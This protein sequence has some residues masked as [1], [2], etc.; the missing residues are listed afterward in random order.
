MSDDPTLLFTV[1]GMVPFKAYFED[2]AI[3]PRTSVATAQK[4]LR[5]IDI[6]DIGDTSHCTFFEMMGNFSFGDY[7]KREAVTWAWEFLT[8]VLKLNPKDLRVTVFEDDDEAYNLWR[9][10]CGLPAERVTRLGEKTNYWPANAI[11][12]HSQGP[13][14]PCS[15]IFFDRQPD[16]PF[17]NEW[18][19]QG[20]RWLEIWNLV[21]TQFTGDGEGDNYRLVPLPKKNIDT[22][23]GLER[24]AAAINRLSGPF[25][26]DLLRPI[27]GELEALSGKTYTGTPDSALDIAF[28]R[29]A[30]HVRA[31]TFLLSDGVTPDRTGRGYVLRRLMRRAIVAG[32]RA[33]GFTDEPFLA[34][35]VPTVIAHMGDAYPDIREREQYILTQVQ[36]EETLFRRTLQNGLARLDDELATGALSGRRAYFLYETFGLPFE[37]TREIAGERGVSV[38]TEGYE[39]ALGEAQELS[40]PRDINVWGDANEAVDNLL[41]SL[42]PTR[43]VGYETPRGEAR[44]VGLVVDNKPVQ[45]ASEGET[46][47]VLL[48][49]TPFYAES[50]GQ[51]GD[52]GTISVQGGAVVTVTDTKKK[53]GL[54][55]HKATVTKGTLSIGDSVLAEVDGARRRD[56][57]RNHT[58]THLL[59]KALRDRL[60]SHVQ[61]RG[62]LVAPDRLRF[63]FAHTQSLSHEDL[64]TVEREVNE[65]ILRELPVEIDEKPIEEAKNLG[66]MML[67]GEKYGATVRVVS[68]GGAYSREFCG[69]TH[70]AN[71]SQIGPFRL[72]S[73]GSAAAG[74][75]RVEALTGRG[76]DAHDTAN[77]ERLKAVASLLGVTG[78]NA[79]EAVEKLQADLKAARQQLA[80]LQRA[81]AGNQAEALAGEAQIIGGVSVVVAAVQGVDDAAALSALADDVLNRLKSGIVVLAAPASNKVLFVAK[82]SKD[83]TARGVHAGNVVKAMATATGGGGGGRP[84]F[85]QAGGKDV[86]KLPDALRV[87]RETLAAQ[88][89]G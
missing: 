38:D 37:I 59:H 79:P 66:A 12:E 11:Q 7:F 78:A 32:I 22:G 36:Q 57:M 73:E 5:T 35:I 27:I 33:L 61:Q 68:V 13:C 54:F 69:G 46:V 21:F 28:R 70:V 63:D 42:A 49:A 67:F 74:V 10:M 60:G 52:T 25:E 71:A 8:G 64:Q 80:N 77:S 65:A 14:G 87:A 89:G 34:R 15:E 50:G 82:A 20:E 3:P 62:S 19:G 2:R 43:F 41:K 48:D 40:R 51:V 56:I 18:D 45:S 23:M 75:R 9:D 17:N 26:T 85:A 30:D 39:A 16:E 72:V 53:N 47:D 84:D 81:Q 44:V 29:I 6:D 55:F 58:A 83:A 31:T 86:G 1:A 76:A 4:C 88:V 24:T